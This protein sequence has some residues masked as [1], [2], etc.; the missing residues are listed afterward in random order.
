VQL[1]HFDEEMIWNRIAEAVSKE[2]KVTPREISPNM[3][4]GEDVRVR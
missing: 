4:I 1:D 2:M 3:R